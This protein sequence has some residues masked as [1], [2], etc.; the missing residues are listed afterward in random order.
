VAVEE[1][2]RSQYIH[3]SCDAWLF[4][5][6]DNVKWFSWHGDDGCGDWRREVAGL[7]QL[8]EEDVEH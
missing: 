4:S 5:P 3:F 1:V 7:K 2:K 6:K 8:I